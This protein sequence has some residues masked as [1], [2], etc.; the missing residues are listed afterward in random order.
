MITLGL[1][2]SLTVKLVVSVL[3]KLPL[4]SFAIIVT[5][6]SP[7]MSVS[8]GTKVKLKMSPA[9]LVMVNIL[10]VALGKVM[11]ARTVSK[12]ILSVTLAVMFTG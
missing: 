6:L 4:V 10:L 5:L 12:P 3:F 2:I 9:R 7:G 8:S 11:F 1:V